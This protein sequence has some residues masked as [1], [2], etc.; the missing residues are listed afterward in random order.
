MFYNIGTSLES[1]RALMVNRAVRLRRK[2]RQASRFVTE[3]DT[4]VFLAGKISIF[5]MFGLIR[6]CKIHR[7]LLD[8]LK[9]ARKKELKYIQRSTLKKDPYPIEIRS[10]SSQIL[11]ELLKDIKNNS[12]K[13]DFSQLL[14][15]EEENRTCNDTGLIL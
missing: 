7:P 10:R 15:F 6:P 11:G 13:V 3:S 12:H 5:N 9:S 2:T 14:R 8:P 1:R 4:K